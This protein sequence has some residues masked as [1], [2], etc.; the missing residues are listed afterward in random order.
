MTDPE[1]TPSTGSIRITVDETHA[2][3]LAC[4]YM[5]DG[6]FRLLTTVETPCTL[7]AFEHE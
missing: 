1:T 5:D 3:A 4:G 2:N 6:E 7:V